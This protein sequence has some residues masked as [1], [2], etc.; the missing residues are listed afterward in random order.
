MLG[1]TLLEIIVVVLVFSVMS[2]MAYGGLRSVLRTRSGIES[3]MTRTAE[4]QRAYMRLRGDF[5]NLRDR[6]ARDAFGDS[7]AA[8]SIDREGQLHLIRGGQRNP[9]GTSRSSLER[10]QYSFK[11]GALRRASWRSLDLPQKSDPA[12]LVLLADVEEVRWRFLDAGYEW[13]EQWPQD[14]QD[15]AAGTSSASDPPPLAVEVTIVTRDWVATRF[16]FRTPQAGLARDGGGPDSSRALITVEG[17]LPAAVLGLGTAPQAPGGQKPDDDTPP[18]D[19]PPPA[20]EPPAPPDTD[21]PMPEET[22]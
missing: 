8:L 22:T 10:I 19:E 4:L 3:A 7:Q 9:L 21:A 20:P 5:Q 11:D 15:R 16:L 1:F 13:Q 6:P 12:D 18:A 2:V 14:A 17:L